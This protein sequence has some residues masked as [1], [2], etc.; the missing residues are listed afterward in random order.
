M[1][2]DLIIVKVN[3]KAL[4]KKFVRFPYDLY[5]GDKYW[6]PP[7]MIEEIKS[8][9]PERNPSLNQSDFGC[10]LVF[11]RNKIVGRVAA[12][13]NRKDNQ[14][15]ERKA[16]RFGMIDFIDDASVCEILLKEV[17]VWTH[18]NELDLVEG[19]LGPGHFDRNCVL[20]DGFDE[21]PTAISSYNYPY[22]GTH[23]ENYGYVK[24]VDYLEH[25]IKIS[26]ESDPRVE[27]ISSYVLKK[28]GLSLWS[29][30]SKK[31]LILRGKEFFNLI[32]EAY[33]GLHDFVSLSDEEIDYLIGHFFSFIE[34]KY[35]KIVVDEKGDIVAAGV[36]M[37]SVSKALKSSGGKLLPFGWLKMFLVMRENDVL[38]LCLIAVANKF[39]GAGLNSII[40]HEMHK[41][42]LNNGL[43]WAETNGELETN[44]RVLTMWN[45]YDYRTHKRRR[46]Y[47][48]T[49]KESKI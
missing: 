6:V 27:K 2:S 18:E 45:G 4:L 14:T 26:K 25:R 7:L 19:P 35:V 33:A 39:R 40:M 20:V 48:K 47:S 1:S 42:A 44:S 36:A 30:R 15:R 46:I 11:R 31:E 24:E 16:V 37:E 32:N 5:E 8:L 28:K 17:E 10:W 43:K 49:L 9:I 12:F 29:A 34:T 22:Y 21:L 38:D 3:K 13:I 23:I 41:T